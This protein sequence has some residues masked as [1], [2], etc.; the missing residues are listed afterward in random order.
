MAALE[1]YVRPSQKFK[2]S[3]KGT[4]TTPSYSPGGPFSLSPGADSVHFFK[5]LQYW[6]VRGLHVIKLRL[7][8]LNHIGPV[9]QTGIKT[10]LRQYFSFNGTS[11]F[12]IMFSARLGLILGNC[13]YDMH[14]REK[15]ARSFQSFFVGHISIIFLH[16]YWHT[17]DPL[18]LLLK[19]SVFCGY[20]FYT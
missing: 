2:L 20:C 10:S 3:V 17:G 5:N 11:P 7:V 13:S 9:S 15:Y 4:D 19:D 16:L 8:P 12:M 1:E 6:F 18:P 14:C